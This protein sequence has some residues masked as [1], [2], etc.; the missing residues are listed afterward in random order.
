MKLRI[1]HI[2]LAKG[3]R[4]GERQTFLLVKALAPHLDQTVMTRK[5]TAL[6]KMVSAIEGVEVVE[7][8]KPF[9]LS[10]AKLARFSLIHAHEA[11]A[12]HIAYG[13][14]IV[15][16]IPYV[17]T[18]RVVKKPK[19]RSFFIHV[20]SRAAGVVAIS[21]QV[22]KVLEVLDSRIRPRVIHSS[23]SAL[24]ADESNI[25]KLKA[26]YKKKFVIGHVGALVNKDKGQLH[27]IN[28]AKRLSS[29]AG[30]IH[31]LFLGSGVDK[32][33]FLAEADGC[34]NMEFLG[35]KKNI[36]D[37]YRLFDLFLFPSLDEGLGS[38]ILDAFYFKLPVIA[39]RTGGIPD[40]VKPYDT[41][42]LVEPKD[43]DSLYTKIL[44][45]YNN[46]GSP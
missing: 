7:I 1:C 44:E 10:I 16:K 15:H 33:L 6:G 39:S 20:Y 41:G 25:R 11:K 29:E 27:I 14:N 3:F 42:I 46:P 13:A 40:I 2:N 34:G 18:R 43:E 9:M 12:A 30:D 17:I 8:R 19:N 37:Y 23:V 24:P 5:N 36:G 22:K 4:G 28:V 32:E 21:T 31:F 45:L 26:D 38:A 35:F